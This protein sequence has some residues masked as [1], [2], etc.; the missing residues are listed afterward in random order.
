[1]KMKKTIILTESELTNIIK[2]IINE[3]LSENTLYSDIKSVIRDSN[4]SNQ[5]TIEVL[6][7]IIDEMESSRRMRRDVESRFRK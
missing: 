5:E 7:S 1:M 4:S 6:K 3:D 2:K